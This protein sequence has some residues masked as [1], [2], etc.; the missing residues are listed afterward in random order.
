FAYLLPAIK[1]IIDSR[2]EDRGLSDLGVDAEPTLKPRVVISTHTIALQEQLLQ[3]DIPLLQA[4]I[5]EEFTAV[6]VKGRGN[7]ISLRRLQRT[8]D[9]AAQLF[10]DH[11]E[12][13]TLEIVSEWA[14]STTDGSLSSLP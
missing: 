6:L 4:V 9:R 5:P 12:Q 10:A 11:E 8:Q 13:E 14:K 1:R 2:H 3:K 7:Y